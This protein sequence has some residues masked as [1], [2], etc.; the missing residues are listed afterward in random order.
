MI[1][2]AI[3]RSKISSDKLFCCTQEWQQKS[4]LHRINGI[5]KNEKHR[6]N[7]FIMTQKLISYSIAL[8]RRFY[9]RC[10]SK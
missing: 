4:K 10:G 7:K 8:R 3:K 2:A 5:T 9:F 1:C 6:Q